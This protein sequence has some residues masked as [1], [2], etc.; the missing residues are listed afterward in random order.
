MCSR[1]SLNTSSLEVL[2]VIT[3]EFIGHYGVV[4]SS[5]CRRGKTGFVPKTSLFP[6]NDFDIYDLAPYQKFLHTLLSGAPQKCFQSVPAFSK[7]GPD[8]YFDKE[9]HWLFLQ[10]P[11]KSCAVSF[12]KNLFR[13]K[14][15]IS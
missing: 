4:C 10:V 6:I 3:H 8:H 13:V 14:N 11:H 2:T 12:F 5:L 1:T 9:K 15:K 7:A